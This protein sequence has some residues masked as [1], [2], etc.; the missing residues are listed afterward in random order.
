MSKMDNIKVMIEERQKKMTEFTLGSKMTKVSGSVFLNSLKIGFPLL[1]LMYWFLPLVSG[2]GKQRGRPQWQA[3][4]RSD[5]ACAGV[6]YE[7]QADYS[8]RAEK[9]GAKRQRADDGAAGG[10]DL[11]AGD[12]LQAAGAV[13]EWRPPPPSAS[14]SPPVRLYHQD[15]CW[16]KV[17]MLLLV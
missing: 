9:V 5:E 6:S 4:Q 12:E 15:L 8:G 16:D 14:Q 3:L 17:K 1:T 7:T 11:A 10:S 2:K 13:A